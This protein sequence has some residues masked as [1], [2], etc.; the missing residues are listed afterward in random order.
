L[1]AE[2]ALPQWRYIA[3]P[4]IR[5]YIEKRTP[6][7][8]DRWDDIDQQTHARVFAVA[9]AVRADI[10]RDLHDG[11]LAQMRA[12]GT[13]EDFAAAVTPV[14][15]QK[16][17]LPADDTR[18]A[19]RLN[20]IFDTNLR[21]ARAQ[22]QWGRL[23]KGKAFAPYLVYDAV[24]DHRT[25]P[26]HSA[27][28]D[29]IAAIDDPFW[30]TFF[31][32]N[33]FNC[34]CLVRAM[35][36]S[37]VARRGGPTSATRLALLRTAAPPDKGFDKPALGVAD[38]IAA[39][40]VLKVRGRAL[41]GAGDTAPTPDELLDQVV[42]AR[43][44]ALDEVRERGRE[45]LLEHLVVL[46]RRTGA[47]VGE[48]SK[49]KMTSVQ[50]GETQLEAFASA[51]NNLVAYHNHPQRTSLS[52]QDVWMAVSP[53]NPGLKEVWAVTHNGSESWV[54]GS[55]LFAKLGGDKTA[56][57]QVDEILQV[58]L[59]FAAREVLRYS[60]WAELINAGVRL[61]DILNAGG[62]LTPAQEQTYTEYTHLNAYRLVHFQELVSAGVL[63]G[64]AMIGGAQAEYVARHPSRFESLRLAIRA[65]LRNLLK[66]IL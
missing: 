63:E 30:Q 34:R 17:W 28:D 47:R 38:R 51:R 14:L 1:G 44:L 55:P 50:P 11:F 18:A 24:N 59:H 57:A 26:T 64:G 2:T 37:Q 48:T 29:V 33:G 4:E 32:P 60:D 56:Q 61:V 22:A 19:R 10:V 27:L 31:P 35:T 20:L 40:Y 13:A 7:P 8:L 54:T 21:A 49:G 36:R 66:G 58:S 39:D 9:G 43:A 15:R 52:T 65:A 42:K 46:D 53:K 25:R 45:T 23:Q 12:G 62:T 5:D 3:A 6:Q 16:G 41:P